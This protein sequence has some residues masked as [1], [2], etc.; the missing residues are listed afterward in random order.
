[1][2]T[3]HKIFLRR[4][5]KRSHEELTI[6]IDWDSVSPE[7]MRRFAEYYVLHRAEHDL[8]DFDRELPEAVT[9][10]AADFIHNEPLVNVNL[11]I[12]DKWKEPPKSKARKELE[13][14]FA[15][16]STDEIQTL[17]KGA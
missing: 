13:K 12:P 9:Y 6:R 16:L 11:T 1:M 15:G 10:R 4:N 2:H 3:S 14:L 17:L 8:K 5:G 7:D